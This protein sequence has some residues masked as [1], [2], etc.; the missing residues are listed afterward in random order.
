MFVQRVDYIPIGFMGT[1]ANGL[2]VAFK[3][4]HKLG[5]QFGRHDRFLKQKDGAS[6]KSKYENRRADKIAS[7]VDTLKIPREKD[8][9]LSDN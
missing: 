5:R 3:T 6:V 1:W 8:I 7:K 2:A 4:N 9:W